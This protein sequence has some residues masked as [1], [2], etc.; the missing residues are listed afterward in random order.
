MN[1]KK[2]LIGTVAVLAVVRFGWY[3]YANWGLITIHAENQPLSKVISEIQRQGHINLK[4]DFPAETVVSM[5]VVKVPLTEALET[6]ATVTD[7][8]WRFTYFLASDKQTIKT[9]LGSFESGQRPEGWKLIYFPFPSQLAASGAAPSDPRKDVWKAGTPKEQTLQGYLE[10]AGKAV[11]VAFSL[12]ETWNPPVTSAP[13]ASR[14][15]SAIPKLVKKAGGAAEELFILSK[16]GGERRFGRGQPPGDRA[17]NE[18]DFDWMRQRMQAEIKKLPPE[19]QATAQA[20]FDKE[21]AFW[22][23]VRELPPEERRAKMREHAEDPEVQARMDERAARRDARRTPEQ[24]LQ[25]SKQYVERKIAAKQ[26]QS[27]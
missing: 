26:A 8:R 22:K 1:R 24:R 14:I 20:D 25:R 4:S 16:P 19:E 13:P 21:Q 3:L 9:A 7:G 23:Q 18:P 2:W 27:K 15:T 5:N 11:N 17:E 10:D 6:L 12:P